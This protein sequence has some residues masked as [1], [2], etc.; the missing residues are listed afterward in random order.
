M[1]LERAVFQGVRNWTVTTMPVSFAITIGHQFGDFLTVLNGDAEVFG[2]SNS[3]KNHPIMLWLHLRQAKEAIQVWVR[4]LLAL[5]S[6][7]FR[8]SAFVVTSLLPLI[9]GW[10]ERDS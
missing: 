4:S 3:R 7:F 1:Y 10:D 6:P 5:F 8:C 9:G 2:S